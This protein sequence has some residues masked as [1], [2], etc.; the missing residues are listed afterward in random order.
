[1]AYLRAYLSTSFYILKIF[2]KAVLASVPMISM[3]LILDP[4]HVLPIHTS[5][6][7]ISLLRPGNPKALANY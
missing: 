7:R 2:E 4:Q 6:R 1:M 5:T 3:I